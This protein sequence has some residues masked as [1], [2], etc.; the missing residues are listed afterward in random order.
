MFE[1]ALG[2]DRRRSVLSSDRE[3]HELLRHHNRRNIDI[4]V[5][6]TSSDRPNSRFTVVPTK[7]PDHVIVPSIIG[8]RVRL[9]SYNY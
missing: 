7:M 9:P 2:F 1:K 3:I 8:S 6:R 4:N 5:N